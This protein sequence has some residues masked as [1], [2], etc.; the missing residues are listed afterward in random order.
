MERSQTD[1]KRVQSCFDHD[2]DV[3][4]VCSSK[5]HSIDHGLVLN[6]ST[7]HL[8]VYRCWKKRNGKVLAVATV[9]TVEQ[10]TLIP[11]VYACAHVRVFVC[12]CV[13]VHMC[14]CVCACVCAR[15]CVC[16]CARVRA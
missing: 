6:L 11:P 8:M 13:R 4:G 1:A 15:V 5:I 14:V 12:A 2:S 7:Q 10:S 3:Y 16:V 9:A